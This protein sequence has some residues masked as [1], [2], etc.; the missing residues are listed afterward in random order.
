[1]SNGDGGFAIE[2]GHYD[3]TRAALKADP[4]IRDMVEGLRGVALDELCHPG[5]GARFEFMAA[6]LKEYQGRGGTVP[7]HIGGP[8]E[9]LLALLREET[10]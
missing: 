8:A 2:A 9:A 4:I 6:A 7:V 1:M 10:K 5:G 3:E